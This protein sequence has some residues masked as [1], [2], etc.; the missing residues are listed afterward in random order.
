MAAVAEVE[1]E[2][3]AAKAKVRDRAGMPDVLDGM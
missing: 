3:D 2:I 1:K